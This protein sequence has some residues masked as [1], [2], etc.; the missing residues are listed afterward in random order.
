MNKWK[1]WLCI[2]FS[3]S[4][5]LFNATDA[6]ARNRDSVPRL[7][8]WNVEYNFTATDSGGTY[9]KANEVWWMYPVFVAR[10]ASNLNNLNAWI[11]AETLKK[12]VA[13]DVEFNDLVTKSDQEVINKINTK[14]NGTDRA[15]VSVHST[16]GRY[17]QLKL[18]EE[19]VGNGYSIGFST[20]FY[21][22]FADEPVAIEN[23]F[24]ENALQDIAEMLSE[25]IEE[26][27]PT[28]STLNW[29]GSS[30]TIH[31]PEEIFIEFPGFPQD[32]CENIYQIKNKKL[33]K[34]FKNSRA[35][36]PSRAIKEI[37]NPSGSNI[38]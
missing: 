8:Y 27:C 25:V 19:S 13:E 31:S 33:H 12:I 2:V 23:L 4:T 20:L 24:K 9:E 32:G 1:L 11:R 37:K 10:D 6:Y 26:G 28:V 5:L 16:I 7:Q 29:Y 30:Y 17:L 36:T 22:L 15:V 3:L 38:K 18:I 14:F 21:D 35:L 34:V